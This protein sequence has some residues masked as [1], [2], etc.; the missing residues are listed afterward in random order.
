MHRL[1]AALVKT[2]AAGATAAAAA[3]ALAPAAAPADTPCTRVAAPNGSDSAAG[4]ESA[5]FRS[6]QKLVNSL[7]PGEVGCLRQGSYAEN[8][9]VSHGGGGDDSRVVLRSYPGERGRISGRLYVRDSADYVTIADLDLDGH[10]APGC[11]SSPTCLLPSPTVNGDHVTFSGDDV[12]NRHAAICFNLG[13]VGYGRAEHDVI[14][15]NRIHDCG[16]L[17]ATNHEHGIYLAY[18]D[19]TEITGNVIYD[20]A[21]RGIQL[22]PDAQGTRVE[23]NVIDGNGV[24][25]IFSGAGSTASNDNVVAHNVITNSKL[26]HDVESWFPNIVGSGNVAH[27]NCVYGGK[28]GEFGTAYGF[29]AHDNLKTDPGYADRAAKD[30]R[31]APDGPCASVLA[32]QDLPAAPDALLPPPAPPLD[33]PAAAVRADPPADAAPVQPPADPAPAGDQPPTGDPPVDPAP[34]ADAPTGPAPADDPPPEATPAPD[35]TVAIDTAVAAADLPVADS[36]SDPAP[37]S[38]GPAAADGALA[39]DL[40]TPLTGSADDATAAASTSEAVDAVALGTVDPPPVDTA[41]PPPATGQ[42]VVA[43]PHERV[44]APPS[45]RDTVRPT[46]AIATPADGVHYAKGARL[47][48]RYACRDGGGVASCTGPV[49]AG[50]RIAARIPGRRTFTVTARDRA[51]NTAKRVVHYVVDKPKRKRRH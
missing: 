1:H 50:H 37:A 41:G 13:A 20:N 51:G 9:T 40:L 10:D 28:Q 44:V 36:T 21:D 39:P 38:D 6:A 3:F 46:L 8:V 23:G 5:P 7:A 49:A 16:E 45:S 34:A 32:A 22:Y 15:G 24:G 17:P 30:F 25:V 47:I 14:S 11:S 27:D 26:R 18:S 19:D 2:A 43:A 29:S 48:A 12:T 42:P 4:T 31:L 35:A 33:A